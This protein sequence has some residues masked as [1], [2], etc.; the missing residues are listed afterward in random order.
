MVFAIH[1]HES[2][3]DLHFLAMNCFQ[4]IVFHYV[5]WQKLQMSLM[6]TIIFPSVM[7]KIIYTWE[8]KFSEM[9]LK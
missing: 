6:S 2:A 9:L 1:V 3:M 5:E 4:N 7:I 8:H